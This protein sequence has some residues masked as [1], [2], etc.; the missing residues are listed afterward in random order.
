[1]VLD[2]TLQV[3][4][5]ITQLCSK[6]IIGIA[7]FCGLDVNGTQLVSSVF[8]SMFDSIGKTKQDIR[9]KGLYWV[10]LYHADQVRV[11][12]NLKV[13][14]SLQ[15]RY[16]HHNQQPPTCTCSNHHHNENEN[17][18]QIEI[19]LNSIYDSL[20]TLW[21][22]YHKLRNST[23]SKRK[24]KGKKNMNT[25]KD[26]NHQLATLCNDFL[27]SVHSQ[28]KGCGHIFSLALFQILSVFGYI[29]PECMKWSSIANCG[30]GGYKLLKYKLE[31]D[32]HESTTASLN[33]I[34]A[35]EYLI[36][37]KSQVDKL[38]KCDVPL[39]FLENMLCE[40]Y[41][42]SSSKNGKS[43]KKDIYVKPPFRK[44]P[45]SIFRY[46]YDKNDNGFVALEMLPS[47]ND[48]KFIE[49]TNSLVIKKS[50]L[51]TRKQ[52]Q[53]YSKEN[54]TCDKENHIS[55]DSST[56]NDPHLPNFLNGHT[57]LCVSL[58]ICEL[59]KYSS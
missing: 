22:S 5:Q 9:S 28:R 38:F 51:F 37:A 24:R 32:Y 55:W 31:E 43:S 33:P 53:V 29:P 56:P 11:D 18:C 23:K 59:Y 30:S 10:L 14:S 12:N 15:P 35:Q 44:S 49:E 7:C 16:M 58:S 8:S 1:M 21:I 52:V 41:R 6:D 13:L 54:M 26:A 3:N 50:Q 34:R 46:V 45:Q 47:T 48:C 42:E 2:L 20:T 17:S 36:D 4:V 27:K 19:S 25:K 57:K 39:V 40:L